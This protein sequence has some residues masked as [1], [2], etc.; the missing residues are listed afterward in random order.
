MST[1]RPG[2]ICFALFFVSLGFLRYQETGGSGEATTVVV[3]SRSDQLTTT[4][5][6]TV[7][8]DPEAATRRATTVADFITQAELEED[9]GQFQT[10]LEERFVLR[11]FAQP[12]RASGRAGR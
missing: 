4:S 1:S 3:D 2:V 10:E 5:L 12:R 9:L 8:L 7:G 6:L 11:Q